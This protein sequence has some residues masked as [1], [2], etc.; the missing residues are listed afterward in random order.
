MRETEILVEQQPPQGVLVCDRAGLVINNS[1]NKGEGSRNVR[2]LLLVEARL[3]ETEFL[4]DNLLVRIHFIIVMIRWTGLA[5]LPLLRGLLRNWGSRACRIGASSSH[6]AL[7][8]EHIGCQDIISRKWRL[9]VSAAATPGTKGEEIPYAHTAQS[10][11]NESPA[12]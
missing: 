3:Q 4:I 12:D 1:L 10:S 2:D 5:A 9:C 6:G 8:D 7:S 11:I